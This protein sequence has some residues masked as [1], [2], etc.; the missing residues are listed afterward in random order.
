MGMSAISSKGAAS[1]MVF[2]SMAHLELC[3]TKDGLRRQAIKKYP[4]V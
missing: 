3:S 4:I 2:A 1:L